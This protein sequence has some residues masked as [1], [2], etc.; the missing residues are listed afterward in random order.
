V[1]RIAVQV[2]LQLSTVSR[3]RCNSR[4]KVQDWNIESDFAIAH[5]QNLHRRVSSMTILIIIIIISDETVSNA[6]QAGVVHGT[7]GKLRF[8]QARNMI[9]ND[10]LQ[11]VARVR[12]NCW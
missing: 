7:I 8:R 4:E 1:N 10:S 5:I 12:N 3:V 11:D 2:L 6:L 9:P